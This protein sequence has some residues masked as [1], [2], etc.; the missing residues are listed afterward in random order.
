[1]RRRDLSDQ[2]LDQVINLKRAG[3]SW[4]KIQRETGIS[5]RTA[6]RAYDKWERG[7]S[8]EELKEAR[9]DVAAQAF[10]EHMESVIT[11][12]ES[13][14]ANL[15]VPS[16]LREMEMNSQQ[17]FS[18]LL[19]EDLLRRNM[20]SETQIQV[21]VGDSPRFLVGDSQSYRREKQLLF[22]SLKAHTRGEVRWEDI[23]DNRWKKS[24]DKCATIV[25]KLGR[26]ISKVLKNLVNEKQQ[27]NLLSNLNEA[28]AGYDPMERIV[29]AVRMAIWQDILGDNLEQEGARFETIS[30]A[31][32]AAH[33]V[34][35]KPRHGIQLEFTGETGKHLAEQVTSICNSAYHNLCKGDTV[36]QLYCEVLNMKKASE[37]IREVL[38]AV[39][40]RPMILRTRCDLCPA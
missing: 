5:R 26:E 33:A 38:N 12:A 39:R 17:F 27:P 11:L 4:V 32:G 1:M 7:K 30:Q 35:A 25:P 24:R 16:S 6:K 23:L 2:E 29:E 14:A 36:Q 15:G 19:E 31:G 37:E 34:C 9:K 8:L 22:E 3:S 40:L 18:W 13:L 21:W 10:R 20:S 28:S